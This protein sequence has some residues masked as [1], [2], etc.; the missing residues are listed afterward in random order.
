MLDRIRRGPARLGVAGLAG[1]VAWTMSV[2]VLTVITLATSFLLLGTELG[3]ENYGVY[4]GLFAVTTPLTT[5]GAASGLAVVQYT[6]QGGIDVDHAVARLW[7]LV[8]GIGVVLAAIAVVI[9]NF[10]VDLGMVEIVA[11]AVSELV[12]SASIRV[13]A[14]SQR[15]RRGVG[16]QMRVEMVFLLVR[17]TVV[18]GLWA[19]DALTIRN[20]AVGWLFSFTALLC[21]IALRWLPSSGGDVRIE[22]PGRDEVAWVSQLGAPIFANNFQL[23]GDKIV[24]N[25]AGLERD[26]GLYGAA[27]RVIMLA[28]LP[29]ESIESAMFHRF[30]QSDE[31]AIGQHVRRAIRYTAAVLAVIAPVCVIVWFAAPFFEV[32]FGSEYGDSSSII[33]WLTLWLPF[34]A[35]SS[36]PLNALMGLQR[37]RIRIWVVMSS[38]VLSMLVYVALIPG[39]GWEGA[40]IGTVVSEVYLVIAGWWALIRA[41]RD[42]DAGVRARETVGVS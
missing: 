10:V 37:Y 19:F 31:N 38:A 9:A 28:V 29:L 2:Q 27:F 3:P 14:A 20:L 16:G 34:Q 33:R 35:M 11:V 7:G 13:L 6:F 30:L 5:V 12:V 1:D 17:F 32:I 24:L 41:Q 25:G 39:R 23:N 26:A 4:V 21:V 18:V 40:V 42:H 36:V 15:W 8:L 22:V